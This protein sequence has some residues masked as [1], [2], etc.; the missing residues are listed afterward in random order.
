MVNV[1]PEFGEELEVNRDSFE[2]D[3]GREVDQHL[4][5]V[6]VVDGQTHHQIDH[7]VVAVE[8]PVQGLVVV[9]VMAV[10]SL[11]L[12]AGHRHLQEGSRGPDGFQVGGRAQ[13]RADDNTAPG[14]V[15]PEPDG[16]RVPG[17]GLQRCKLPS[18]PVA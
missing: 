6:A 12:T 9:R 4:G 18:L 1:G 15:G 17:V 14:E 5:Q 11:E 13:L 8:V 10:L 7:Q 16:V 3:H 2:P